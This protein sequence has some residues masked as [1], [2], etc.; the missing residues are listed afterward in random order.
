MAR[1]AP[2]PPAKT[3]TGEVAVALSREFILAK[4]EAARAKAH[5]DSLRDALLAEL[6]AVGDKDDAG[7]YTFRL[8]EAFE[9]FYGLKRQRKITRKL[10]EAAAIEIL[11]ALP[12]HEEFFTSVRII[13]EDAVMAALVEGTITE[14]QVD[15]M[16]PP[17]ESFAL[18]TEKK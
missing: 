16:F 15:T 5:Q 10:D 12:E 2:A 1:V 13:D 7:H 17:S 8:P 4:R 11:E 14:E 9:G 3:E 18:L 6:E